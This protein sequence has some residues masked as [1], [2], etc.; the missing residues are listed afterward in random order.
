MQTSTK[1]RKGGA[2]EK[3]RFRFVGTRNHGKLLVWESKPDG[4]G[5][6]V[7]VTVGRRYFHG[8]LPDDGGEKE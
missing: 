8:Q 2:V 3:Y 4:G 5:S 1:Q 7:Q 6:S